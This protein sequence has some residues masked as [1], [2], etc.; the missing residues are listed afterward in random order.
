MKT[1]RKARLDA[2][3]EAEKKGAEIAYP[4]A[5]ALRAEARE[6]D[7]AVVLTVKDADGNVVRR[8]TGPVKA[9]VHRVAWDLR[10]PASTPTSLKPGP[11][12]VENPF[13]DAP[14]GPLVVPGTYTVSFEKRVDG[15]LAAFGEPQTFPVESLGLQTLK[16]ADAAELLAFER[17]TARLQRAV[18]GAIEAAE[19]AQNRAQGGEE[20]DRRH[21]RPRTRRSASRR[22]ASRRRSTTCWSACAATASCARRNEPDADVDRRARR[23]HRRHASGRPPSPPP[24]PA[25]RPTPIAAEAFEKQLADACGR[26]SRPTS[27]PSR[28]RWRRRARPGPRA[29]CPPGRRSSGRRLCR[30]ASG[31]PADTDPGTLSRSRPP[32]S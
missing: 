11:T 22:G 3:K 15:V 10:F 7:P 1:K 20:G 25:A 17:K 23:G 14:A 16:A 4:D 12:P 13:Y 18:L 19:E 32:A 6:E 30:V 27:G 26:S 31:R 28:G 24:A 9:G 5:A 21:A 2:E 8:L 29:A